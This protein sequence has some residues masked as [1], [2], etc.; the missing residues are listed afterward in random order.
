MMARKGTGGDTVS[1]YLDQNPHLARWVESLRDPCES[2]KQW[3]ARREFILRNMEA[4]P[5]GQAGLDRLLSLSM[6]WANHVFLGCRYPQPVMDK[7]REMADGVEV[8]EAPVRKTRDELM[9]RVKRPGA[10]GG[11]DG[12]VKRPSA[13][14]GEGHSRGVPPPA[15]PGPSPHAPAQH[16][17]FFNRLYKAVAWK[18]VS[19][20]GFGPNL[21]HFEILRS[22][23]ETS[24]ASLSCVI[25]PLKDIPDLPAGRAQKEGQVCEL[26]C[27]GVYLGT[28]YGRDEDAARAMASKEALK[29]FQ[30]RKVT[31][32]ICRRRFRGR[33]VEDVV[34]V[35]EQPR[36]SAFPP[37]LGYPFPVRDSALLAPPTSL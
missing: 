3:A 11:E 31:V 14:S 20:G 34:L 8:H 23:V 26:R 32:K 18:L 28:G 13:S 15:K 24:K 33:D 27:Q 37:A 1:E 12:C 4:F 30:G 7:I 10:P 19:E 9:G 16:Q 35:D 17:P 36:G 21:D 5:A 29:T 2:S 6:A 22:C 25:V